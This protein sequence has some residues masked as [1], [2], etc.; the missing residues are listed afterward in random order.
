MRKDANRKSKS[1]TN[2]PSMDPLHSCNKH[3]L[4]PSQLQRATFPKIY[5]HR[6]HRSPQGLFPIREV[7][8]MKKGLGLPRCFLRRIL[9]LIPH[10]EGDSFGNRFDH[11][12]E[13][14]G[15]AKNPFMLMECCNRMLVEDFPFWVPGTNRLRNSLMPE[16]SNPGMVI[17]LIH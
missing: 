17:R 4:K 9:W 14:F 13:Q 10:S 3:G 15:N 12:H 11:F 2:P 7:V 8:G 5:P 16:K 1:P 6:H